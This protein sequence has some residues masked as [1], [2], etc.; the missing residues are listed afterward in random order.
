MAFFLIG[1]VWSD[2][3]GKR[4]AEILNPATGEQTGELPLAEPADL[5][6]ALSAAANG[7]QVWSQISAYE[8]SIIMRRTADLTRERT[9]EIA[10]LITLEQGKPL[11]EARME[12][13]SIGD[14]IDWYAEEGRRAYGRVIPGRQTN[15][16]QMALK[17][18]IGPIAA[19][20]PWNF[21]ANSLVR[22]IAGA[23]AAGCSII[24]KAPEET[25]S[26]CAAAVSAF[27]DAGTPP[28]VVNLVFGV[29]SEISDHLIPSPVI[30]KISFTGSVPVGRHLGALAARHIKRATME[31]GGHAPFIVCNDADVQAAARLGAEMKF[32]NAGQVC[33]SPT[34]FYA[35]NDVFDDFL[36]HFLEATRSIQVGDGMNPDSRMGPLVRR[37]RVEAIDSFVTDA[38]YQGASLAF[39]TESFP[40]RGFFHGATVL[41]DVP[42]N[43]SIMRDEPF[44]PIAVINKVSSCEEAISRANALPFGLAAY[45]FT[46][47]AKTVSLL[48]RGLQSGMIS[49]N[50]NGL[51]TPE[52]PFGGMMDSGYGSEGGTEG[53]DAYLATKFVSHLAT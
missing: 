51:S 6:A 46:R 34:R 47:S 22:K 18:P 17:E 23:L 53:L 28:G 19:F 24:I 10:N 26:A 52:T 45:G 11:A 8:R 13:T 41:A 40:N 1:G 43:A 50:H 33:T 21:P 35:E 4:R 2:G 44:G 31:L 30:R 14:W 7:F 16:R 38:V 5:E 20:S 15:V 49:I 36:G 37:R 27:Q 29:P 25:P 3:S 39:R 42:D 9:E 48:A 12:V 32:R